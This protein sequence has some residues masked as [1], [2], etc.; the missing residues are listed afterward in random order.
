MGT[1]Y[2][3]QNFRSQDG[4]FSYCNPI[5][6]M[7]YEWEISKKESKK[8]QLSNGIV[9]LKNKHGKFGEQKGGN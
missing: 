9:I 8:V 7:E 5:N 3:W 6:L 1:V 2:K 4:E